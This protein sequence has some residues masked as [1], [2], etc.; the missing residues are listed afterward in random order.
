MGTAHMFLSKIVETDMGVAQTFLGNYSEYVLDK[1]AWVE[2]QR[3][4]WEKQQK[5]IFRTEEMIYRLS[6]GANSGRTTSAV[7]VLLFN[8]SYSLSKVDV[9]ESL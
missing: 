5:E 8:I 6:S 7:K 4:V 3:M 2:A 9:M 1:A